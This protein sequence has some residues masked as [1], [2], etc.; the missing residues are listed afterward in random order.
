MWHVVL[1]VIKHGKKLWMKAEETK[2]VR[3]LAA[4]M[5][6]VNEYSTKNSSHFAPKGIPDHRGSLSWG[7]QY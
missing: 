2:S 5:I 7:N 4:L 1:G 6:R 3:F